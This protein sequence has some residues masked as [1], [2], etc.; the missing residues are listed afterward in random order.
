MDINNTLLK[1]LWYVL[2]LFIS[3]NVYSQNYVSFTREYNDSFRGDMVLIGNNILNRQDATNN[4]NVPFNSSGNNNSF[5][6]QYIDIDSDPTTFSSSSADLTIPAVNSGC[7]TVEYAALYWAGMYKQADVDNGRVNRA[8]LNTVK[9]KLPGSASYTN[10]TGTVLHDS[11]PTDLSGSSKGYV[12]YSVITSLIQGLANANGTYTVADLIAGSGTNTSAGWTLYIVYS[13]PLATAKNISMFHGFSTISG[14]NTLNIPISGFTTIPIGPVRSKLAFSSLEGDLNITGDRLRINGSSMTTATRPATNFFNSTINDINGAYTARVPNSTNLLGFDAGIINVPNPGNTV[15]AN[16]STN[17]TIRLESSGDAYFYYLNAFAIEIIQPNINLIKI[18][19]DLAGNNIANATVNLGQELYYDLDF[20]NIGN[21]GATNFTI[22]DVLPTNVDFIPAD[23][24]LPPG[25]TYVYDP[26]AHS[27]TFT[28]PDS[29]VTQGGANYQIRIKVRVLDDC[30]NLRDACSNEIRNQAFKTYSSLNSG[31]VVE[32][33]EPSASGINSCLI[34]EPGTTNFLADIDDCTFTRDEILCGANVVLTAG[35]GYLSYQWHN[36]APPTAANAIA[37]ATNQSY[38]AT[39]LGTYSVVNTAPAPCLTIVETINVVDFNGVTPNPVIPYADQ[40]D[41]CPNDGSELPKIYLCGATDSQL[42]QTNILNATSII[43]EQLDETSCAAVGNTSCPNTNVS[44]TWNQVGTGP[45]FNA[46]TAGQFRVRIVYQNGCFR[47]YYFNVYQNLFTPTEIHSDIIC[48]TNGNITVN[49][50]P[51]GY[52]FSITGPGG[53]WQTSNIFTITTAGTYTVYI[54]QIG[55]GVGN[56]LFTLPNIQILNRNFTVDVIVADAL[57]NNSRGSIRVQVNNVNP[58]YTYTLYQGA[59][60][61]NS[62][63]PINPN[64]YTFTNLNPGTYTVNVSTSDGC[65]YSETVT[66]NNPPLLTVTAG[67]TIPLTCTQGQITVYPVGGTPPYT[68]EISGTAGFQ[69]VPEFDILTAGTYT[70]TVTDFNGCTASTNLTINAVAPPVFTVTQTDV[71][72]YGDATGQINFNVTNTNA[73]TLLYSIDNGVTFSS[74]P[75]FSNLVA[76]DYQTLVQYS[77]AGSVCLTTVQTITIAQPLEALTASG[78]VSELAGCGPSGEGRVRITNPQGGTPPYQYSF[79][80]GV[81]YGPVSDAYLAPGTY[82]LYIRDA[83]GCVFPMAVT[84]DPA[85]TDP[86]ITV[87]NPIFNC[88][89]TSSTTITVNN[90]G[91]SF[92][93][94]YLLD[95]VV[96][97]NVPDNVFV[98]VPCGN[99]TISVQYQNLLIPTYSNLLTEDFG[100]GGYT[101]SPGINPAY[102]FERQVPATQC[103]SNLQI[104]DGEYAV[105]SIINPRYGAW[106]D[107]RDHTSNGTDPQGR[108]LA[109]NI[110]GVAGVGGILYSK[111]INDI[112]PNQPVRGSIWA[113]NL[114]R[115]GNTQFDPNLTLQ[116]VRDLGLPTETIIATQDTGDIPKTETW[117]NYVLTLNPGANTSLAFVIRSNNT[118]TSGNDVVIDDLNVYQEPVACITEVNYPIILDCSAA[119][120]AQ[121]TSA[122]D[123]SCNGAA[124]GQVTISAQNFGLPYGFDYSIDGGST[125]TNST[126]SPVTISGLAAATYNIQIRY[127]NSATTC[128]FPFTQ[129]IGQPSALLASASLTTPATCI[130]GGSITASASGGTPNYQYQLQNGVGG[131]LVAYQANPVFTNLVPGTYVVVVRDALGCTDPIDVSINIPAPVNPTATVDVTS[132]LCYDGTNAATIVVSATGGVPPYQYSLNGGSNQSSN[133]FS[134]LIPG[135]YTIVVTDSYGCTF[136][137]PAVTIQPQL[138]ARVVLTSNLNCTATPDAIISGTIQGGTAPFS[139]QVSYNAGA[140]SASIP[141]VGNTFVHNAPTAGTY[142]FT[143]TDAIGCTSVT[144]VITVNPLPV[145]NPPVLAIVNPIICNGDSNGSISVTNSG[146]LPPYVINVFNNTTSVNYGTQTTGLTAGNYTVTVTDANSCVT[147]SNIVLTQPD[148]VDFIINKLDIQCG[149]AG[150]EPG[151]IEVDNV[152]GGTSPFTYTVTNSFGY[153]DIYNAVTNENHTFNI[154]NFGVYTVTVIDANGCQLVQNNVTIASPPNS[155][156]IDLTTA[157]TDCTVGGTAIVSVN[158]VVI[159]GPYYFAIYQDLT[160]AI[161]PY[162]TFPNPA[163]Q[164][165]DGILPAPSGLESTFTGLIPGVTYSFIVYDSSTNCYYFET[166]S[167]PIPTLSSM[168]NSITPKN[169]T[170]TGA[171]DGSVSFTFSG[172][173]GTSVSYQIYTALNNLP[174]GPVGTSNGLTGMPVTVNNFGTL[175]VGIYYVLFTE[176]DGPNMNCSTASA[177]FTISQSP[178]LLGLSVSSTNDNCNVNAGTISVIGSNGTPPY[179]YQVLPSGSVAPTEL[180][181]AGQAS[182]VFNVEG[183]LYDVYIMDAYGC[184]RTA[185]INVLT[186]TPPNISLA[187]DATTL[188]NT[189]EGNYS[190]TI[191]RDNTVG[192]GP[193]TYSVDGSAFTTFAED[194]SFSFVLTGLNSGL[195]TIIIRDSNNCTETETITINPPLSGTVTPT[196]AVV[197]DCG[198]SDGI[199]TVNATGGTGT[200]TYSISP[201]VGSLVGNV[202]SSVPAG[203]YTITVTDAT[204]SCT[205]DIPVTLATPAPVTFSATSTDAT[206]NAGTDGSISIALTGVFTDPVYTY[207]ITAPIIIAPQTSNVFNG[208]AAGNYTV[209][210]TSGRGCNDTQVVTVGEPAAVTISAASVVV[211]QFGCTTGNTSNNATIEVNGVTGG[212]GTYINYEFILGGTVVQSGTSNTYIES[213]PTGGLYTINV[214]DNNGCSGTINATIDPFVSISFSSS[215]VTVTQPITCANDENI[216]INVTNTGGVASNLEYIVTGLNGNPYNV[217]QLNNPNFTGLTIGN[218]NIT[219]NNLDTGCSIETIHYVFNPNTF[220]VTAAVTS[221]VI[222]FGTA[223]GS[224]TLTFID[225]T[226]PT[227]EAGPFNYTVIHQGTGATVATGTS[228]GITQS[229]TGLIAGVYQVQTTLVASPECPAVTNFTITGPAAALSISATSTRITC[230]ATNDDGTIS[231]SALNGWGAPYEFQLELG[232][233]IITPWSSTTNFTNLGP[234]NYTVRVRDSRGCEDFTNVSLVIPT[235]ITGTINASV[236]NLPCVGDSTASISITGVSGGEGANYLYVLTNTITGISTAPQTSNVFNDLGAGTYEVTISDSF[237]C[238][239]T[240]GTVTISEPTD[241]VVGTLAITS[242]P[243]CTTNATLSLTATGGT[244]PY[245]Y[246]LTPGGPY[247]PLPTIFNNVL[248]GTYQYYIIDANNCIEVVSNAI[249]VEPVIP[250]AVSV[251]LTNAIINCNG[252]T[253]TVTATAINGLGNYVYTLLPIGTTNNTGIFNGVPAG[254]YTVSVTSGDCLVSSSPFDINEPTPI[255]V[256][257]SQTNVTCPDDA[258]DG[259]IVVTASGGTG[260]IQYSISSAPNETVNSGVFNNLGPGNYT[261]YVQDQL[262]CPIAPLNFTITIPNSFA[263]SSL[264][265]VNEVCLGDQGSISFTVTGGSSSY[266]NPVTGVTSNG[267]TATNGATTQT[268]LTGDFAF[269]NLDYGDYDFIITDAAGCIFNISQTILAGVDV[270]EDYNIDYPCTGTVPTNVLTVTYNPSIPLTD[271]TFSLDGGLPQASNVFNALS[272]GNHLITITHINGCVVTLPVFVDD[273]IALSLT[274]SES[275]LNTITATAANGLPAYEYTFMDSAGNILYVGSDPNYLISFTDTYT[276]VVVDANGCTTSATIPMTFYDVEIPDYFT[277]DDDGNNDTWS[278]LYTDNFPNIVTY[279]FDRYG[280]VII[281]LRQGQSWDGTYKGNKL[282]SGDYWYVIKLN[283]DTDAREFVGNFTLYR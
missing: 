107:P 92:A 238:S 96:N 32:N 134:G 64:D 192:V 91:G 43:W 59:T 236:T 222:C 229:L 160:P 49:G 266:T 108:F 226:V 161:P 183:G 22:T 73:Y 193:F 214:Y 252:G 206:C 216:T 88:D 202:F 274:L 231:A 121:I 190:V 166:A 17:A 62:V 75:V 103:N 117:Q 137:M 255:T 241:V 185:P 7:Y 217:T 60:L 175:P 93:Y 245:R 3:I 72:C 260:T 35:S 109:V 164:P 151:T 211:T 122:S 159:G 257:S 207:E 154:L 82:T 177:N 277:P 74:N 197:Q 127:D 67:I 110:G 281:T 57:C 279:V 78:G 140:L 83:N 184:I 191:T 158:P 50:V 262:G 171:A 104:G 268:S 167:G 70:F 58:Q 33:G 15:I 65:T 133:T 37:G 9:L 52:E 1:K 186:D 153:S 105:T 168:T 225:Q 42:I 28:I 18:V 130:T 131:V 258:F 101:T 263:L 124:D 181:W 81:S 147:S 24:I 84:I 283:G 79:D 46:T 38:T 36:G 56:C 224:A 8:N 102:C 243:T 139:Y 143:I 201:I 272:P 19:R 264:S 106:V 218:Y 47:T 270:Q 178:V 188:C 100:R 76:G 119:F 116:L 180:T 242:T 85:P 144:P 141:V 80:N 227:D 228:A 275:G 27:L 138:L 233:S 2:V 174:V 204:T 113:M 256:V 219:V 87:D 10:I 261:V 16:G 29:L 187:L 14:T 40:V 210:V 135:N 194:A 21:D 182:N 265:V 23:L 213:N 282:P 273:F 44:C 48:G 232:A 198:L 176:N 114:L 31:N 248:P 120:T 142:Q 155:L 170:C 244:A 165:A 55:G 251:D 6:M 240:T 61:I 26:I 34:L 25:V 173:S 205:F 276:V 239:F 246:S 237:T 132:D 215:S 123:V 203:S 148:P 53:P 51:A 41:I 112:I 4:P 267:Y 69:A 150:T 234:G 254:T 90:N 12:S 136:T 199:I 146:G 30:N 99:H 223:T 97:T 63:G 77:L 68:Y 94:T 269:L 152:T 271:L 54:R 66:I 129:V 13:D 247:A 212:S 71:L 156:D 189:N 145:L 45:N 196:I 169:I 115:I 149:A 195:H 157:T 125:W 259:S 126:T 89:G 172:Y 11:Y 220:I 278:P 163:Y 253:S 98:D 20:Q 162:P 5:N 230:I 280:R 111:Q 179:S 86:T 250:L 209:V 200:Y 39:A 95:G 118:A 235:P 128:S 221:N 249:T 208:L